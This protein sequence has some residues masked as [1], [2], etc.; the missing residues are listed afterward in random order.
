[1]LA[2]NGSAP[3]PRAHSG[4]QRIMDRS[5]LSLLVFDVLRKNP[6]THVHAVE[7]EI[8]QIADDYDRHDVL[9]LHEI[10]WDL[11]VQGVLAPGKNSLNLN[12]PFV[13][14]HRARGRLSRRRKNRGLRPGRIHRAAHSPRGNGERFDDP[15]RRPRSALV[16]S[17]RPVRCVDDD[18]RSCGRDPVRL[19]LLRP[20][21]GGRRTPGRQLD[22]TKPSATPSATPVSRPRSRSRPAS[23]CPTYTRFCAPSARIPARRG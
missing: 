12:L 14:R 3:Y 5:R 22:P 16:L 18:A 8:R 20:R 21:T 9:T 2:P 13:P 10:I 7:N 23:S 4:R 1:M 15:R 11:L 17:C 19:H 6:Q